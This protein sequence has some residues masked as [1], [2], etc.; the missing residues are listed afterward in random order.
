MSTAINTRPTK[1][2]KTSPQLP[3]DVFRNIMSFIVDP[4]REDRKKHAR[5]WQTIKVDYTPAS[6]IEEDGTNDCVWIVSANLPHDMA[7]K[8]TPEMYWAGELDLPLPNGEMLQPDGVMWG[9]EEVVFYNGGDN[10]WNKS[11]NGETYVEV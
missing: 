11:W 6:M 3:D 4:Y 5:I 1:R 2:A 10:P 9:N 8:P 7:I